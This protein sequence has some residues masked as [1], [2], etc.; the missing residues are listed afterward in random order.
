MSLWQTFQQWRARRREQKRLYQQ[1][2]L[3][4]TLV[5]EWQR[6]N[7]WRYCPPEG[8]Q[9]EYNCGGFP[10]RMVEHIRV[11]GRIVAP[12]REEILREVG[13]LR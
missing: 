11:H 2:V 5:A 9:L 3:E 4:A 7:W 10:L 1:Q 8:W 6:R 12:T 13:L